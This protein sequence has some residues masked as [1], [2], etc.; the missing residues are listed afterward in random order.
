[1]EVGYEVQEFA[2]ERT[3]STKV[4]MASS[5]GVFPRPLLLM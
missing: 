4:A 3:G 1:M 2:G 5:E